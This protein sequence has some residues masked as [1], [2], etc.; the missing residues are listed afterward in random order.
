MRLPLLP[1]LLLSLAAAPAAAEGY[2]IYDLG[3]MPD[4]PACLQKAGKVL[5]TYNRQNGGQGLI[6][7]A[8]WIVYGWD[9]GPGDNDV[10]IMC[11]IFREEIVNAMLVVYGEGTDEERNAAADG[12]DGLWWGGAP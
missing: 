4:R 10:F 7:P 12:I 3:E 1:A 11:P 5:G 2:A 8:E 6:D 9:F